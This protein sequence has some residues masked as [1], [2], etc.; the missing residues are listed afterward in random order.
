MKHNLF[1]LIG[2]NGGKIGKLIENV[3]INLWVYVLY[4]ICLYY[5]S[6]VEG[7]FFGGFLLY[8]TYISHRMSHSVWPF[9]VVH[10]Y[11]HRERGLGKDVGQF[12]YD[13]VILGGGLFWVLNYQR[14]TLVYY[15]CVYISIHFIN[16]H[17]FGSGAHIDHHR[18]LGKNFSPNFFD[19]LYDTDDGKI[20]K[21][22]HMVWN[23]LFWFFCFLAYQRLSLKGKII[24]I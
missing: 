2:G 6:G 1:K 13:I 20:E 10:L 7:M 23:I 18:D 12:F 24:G 14:Q 9:S 8:W 15:L 21:S 3:L 5:L 16:Y 17:G 22:G 4:G 11:H 19:I